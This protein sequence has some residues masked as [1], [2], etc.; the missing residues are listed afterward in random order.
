MTWGSANKRD[1]KFAWL[2]FTESETESR[3]VLQVSLVK[4]YI[5]LDKETEATLFEC[6]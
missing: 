6:S 2:G 5:Y 1:D 3:G 4:C